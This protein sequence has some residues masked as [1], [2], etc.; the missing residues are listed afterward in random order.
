MENKDLEQPSNNKYKNKI[1]LKKINFDKIGKLY[2]IFNSP[3]L[4]LSPALWQ[5]LKLKSEF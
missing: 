1:F 4:T 2:G 5:S 3:G